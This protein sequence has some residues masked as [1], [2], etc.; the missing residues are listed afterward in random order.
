[1]PASPTHPPILHVRTF[2]A[3]S[4]LS[5][6]HSLLFLPSRK[7]RESY[8]RNR[9]KSFLWT[10]SAYPSNSVFPTRDPSETP[11]EMKLL[12]ESWIEESH[13]TLISKLIPTLKNRRAPCPGISAQLN[14]GFSII[15]LRA[16]G[17]ISLLCTGGC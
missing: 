11:S 16:S 10:Y 3:H 7:L 12:A 14:I 13:F 4:S 5:L 17:T 15:T 6:F 1:M 8:L 2:R 9:D